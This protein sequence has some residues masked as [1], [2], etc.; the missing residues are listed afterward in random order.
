MSA[1]PADAGVM[2]ML[3]TPSLKFACPRSIEPS[4][5]VTVPVG[6]PPPMELTVAVSVTGS[7]KV[8][9]PGDDDTATWVRYGLVGV[10]T[11]S[12]P[13][14]VLTEVPVTVAVNV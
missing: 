13:A 14:V 8:G 2:V 1:V 5:K 6:V 9:E 7:P 3:A 12:V 4:S 11:L 10:V